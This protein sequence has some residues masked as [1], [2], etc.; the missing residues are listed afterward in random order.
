MNNQ[1]NRLALTLGTLLAT[2]LA[3]TPAQATD[4][5]LETE[6]PTQLS[7]EPRDGEPDGTC[8]M[9]AVENIG[10]HTDDSGSSAATLEIYFEDNGEDELTDIDVR[11]LLENGEY[12]NVTIDSVELLS[13]ELH[14]L[15][16][17]GGTDWSW[18]SVRYAWV[19]VQ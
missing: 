5:V 19:E 10:V 8:S 14:V 6:I 13:H 15:D 3:S 9:C 1:W 2:A 4:G 16:V 18:S 7:N 11:V 12:R 17:P